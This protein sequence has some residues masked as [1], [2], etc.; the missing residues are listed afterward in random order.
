M[1]GGFPVFWVL[2]AFNVLFV[3]SY[4]YRRMSGVAPLPPPFS[5][6]AQ[7]FFVV[8]NCVFFFQEDAQRYLNWLT[9][10]Y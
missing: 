10:L 3:G 4:L 6:L 1:S 2:V 9:G 5:Y 8:I 7:G